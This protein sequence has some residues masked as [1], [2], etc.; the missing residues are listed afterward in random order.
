[1]T[2]MLTLPLRDKDAARKSFTVTSAMPSPPRFCSSDACTKNAEASVAVL[3]A[4]TSEGLLSVAVTAA[5]SGKE[6]DETSGR[7]SRT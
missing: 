7:R 2:G 3:A 1:M 6:K 4:S 5:C